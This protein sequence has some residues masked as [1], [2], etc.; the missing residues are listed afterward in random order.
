MLTTSR[1]S[2]AAGGKPVP[3]NVGNF[4]RAETD[5]HFA[6]FV[7]HGAFGRLNHRR[8]MTPIDE[9]PTVRMNRDTLYSIGVFDLEA[10]SLTVTLPD[11]GNAFLSMQVVSQDHFTIEVVYAPGRFHYTKGAV[12]TRYVFLMVRML[13][14]PNDLRPAH[15]LQDS[16]RVSQ[17]SRGS[18]AVPNWDRASLDVVRSGLEVLGSAG[19][20]SVMFG[21]K[22]DVDPVSHHIGTAIGWGGH[23]RTAALYQSVFPK[24]NDG[25]TAHTLTVKDVPVEGFW[26]ISVYNAK[27][28]FEKNALGA[29]GINSLTGHPGPDGSVT[30]RFGGC[31]PGTEN[32]LPIV[33][34]WNYTVRMYRPG[35]ALLDG[36]WTFPEAAPV[37]RSN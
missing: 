2:A 1:A 25:V 9:Q 24:H 5:G 10:A 30:V 14:T 8:A 26:S 6:R 11:P 17:A 33:P 35:K 36:S 16:I 22:E 23:P 18:F 34:G 20:T 7:K 3:V 37:R 27:G 21:S 13:A 28:Y 15:R 4:I 12:G 19:G 29:Y 32:C 31:Q